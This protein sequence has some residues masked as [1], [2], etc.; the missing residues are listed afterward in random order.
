MRIVSV[1][2]D[3]NETLDYTRLLRV[4]ERSV[5][6]HMPT[7]TFIQRRIPAPKVPVEVSH[8]HFTSN[9]VKLEIWREE[10]D[11]ADEPI[12]FADCDMLAT[13]DLSEIFGQKVS[14]DVL[15]K[16]YGDF[17][18]A[19]TDRYNSKYPINGGMV[20]ANPTPAAR[21]FFALWQDANRRL[22]ED[23]KEHK[24]WREK[25]A[26]M[27]QAALGMLLETYKFDAYVVLVPCSTWNACDADWIN[28]DDE[29]K[30]CHI[31]GR[32]RR[33]VLSKLQ[34]E[35]MQ[36]HLRKIAKIWREYEDRDAR[37]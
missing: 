10:M 8:T 30:A 33:S 4:F 26:G 32:M 2:F 24:K 23:P 27:N 36:P 29:V 5:S 9:T 12:V 1:Q 14:N 21:E 25:Y 13:G 22:Y 31:K 16:P 35:D 28:F 17:D 18:I 3:F 7:A 19:L 11:R 15:H 34:I 6:R 37:N 20:Y